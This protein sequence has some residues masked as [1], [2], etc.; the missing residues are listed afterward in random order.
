[1]AE[2]ARQVVLRLA[3]GQTHPP[4]AP[5]ISVRLAEQLIAFPYRVYYD[6]Q[7]L[8]AALEG[9]RDSALIGACLGTR[10]YNGFL[11]EQC[12][13]RLLTFDESW[14][15]AFVIQL[16]GE[17]V[18]EIVQPI[19]DRYA[20][21]VEEK[22]ADFY[23]QNTLHCRYLEQRAISYWNEQ[24]RCRFPR[25]ADYPA[26]RAFAALKK[27]AILQPCTTSDSPIA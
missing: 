14:T 13:H 18:L 10:H 7:P 17:Y 6:Q 4:A 9:D 22:Y 19:H 20:N 1:M 8:L 24:Y 12:L 5:V 23:R 26:V 2:R 15:A 27:A 16:L 3:P 21:G 25:H 11:R